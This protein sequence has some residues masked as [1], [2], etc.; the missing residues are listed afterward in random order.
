MCRVPKNRVSLLQVGFFFCRYK[1]KSFLRGGNFQDSLISGKKYQNRITQPNPSLF[2][3]FLRGDDTCFVNPFE[4]LLIRLH[5]YV[6][7][8][9]AE[10]DVFELHH[11]Y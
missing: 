8:V 11:Y 6:V 2:C 4:M 10:A 7:E 3:L 9:D 1:F 5:L